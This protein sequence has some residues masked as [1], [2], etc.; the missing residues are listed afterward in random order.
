MEGRK[1]SKYNLV[2]T[3]PECG[4]LIKVEHIISVDLV[5]QGTTTKLEGKDNGTQGNKEKSGTGEPESTSVRPD[6]DKGNNATEPEPD[7][8]K[9]SGNSAATGK[10]GGG[11][12]K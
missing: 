4:K 5:E 1:E 11:K 10:T 8:K 2:G 6:K 9:P 7:N 12:A 3:C